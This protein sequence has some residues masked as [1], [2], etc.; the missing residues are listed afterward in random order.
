MSNIRSRI[1]ELSF[2]D[3]G[4]LHVRLL[5]GMEIDLENAMENFEISKQ[6]T[7]GKRYAAFTDARATLT[8]TKEAMAFGSGKVANENLIA[9][10]I[11]IQS[12]ANRI[13]GN[14]MIKFHKPLAP[15]RLFSKEEEA[16]DWLRA[17]VDAERKN[18]SNTNSSYKVM[19]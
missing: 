14:F 19:L 16:M 11:L 6:L 13:L 5:E 10:A 3:E 17:Q 4:I 18:T 7:K 1:A 9:Q 8:I 15:T 2:S 12:L